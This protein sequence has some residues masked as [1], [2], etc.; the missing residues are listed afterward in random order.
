VTLLNGY[1]TQYVP[2]YAVFL[3]KFKELGLQIE[4][5]HILAFMTSF[6]QTAEKQ[7]YIFGFNDGKNELSC[8]NLFRKIEK[9]IQSIK[10]HANAFEDAFLDIEPE[11]F[12][13]CDEDI[14]LQFIANQEHKSTV[15]AESIRRFILETF[16]KHLYSSSI[17]KMPSEDAECPDCQSYPCDCFLNEHLKMI[18][19]QRFKVSIAQTCKLSPEP[20]NTDSFRYH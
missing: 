7:V 17:C 10:I 8:F 14:L 18:S 12:Q 1:L 20:E 6:H 19:Q 13:K 16:G 4:F 9:C 15:F 3:R 2:V 11:Q 5:S